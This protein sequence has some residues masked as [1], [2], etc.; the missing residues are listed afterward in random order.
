MIDEVWVIGRSSDCH[1]VVEHPSVSGKH[2]EIRRTSHGWLLKDLGSTNGTYVN[3]VR[4]VPHQAVSVRTTDRILLAN[5][6][7]MPWPNLSA[8]PARLPGDPSS[9]SGHGRNLEPVQP[10]SPG[11]GVPR[12]GSATPAA[13]PPVVKPVSPSTPAAS[14]AAGSNLGIGPGVTGPPGQLAGSSTGRAIRIGRAPDND[15]VLDHPTV[16]RYHARLIETANGWLLEDLGSS[17]GTA[18]GHPYNRVLQAQ[19]GPQDV[20]YLGTLRVPVTDLLNR[21]ERLGLLRP[22]ALVTLGRSGEQL[23]ADPW[24]G[25]RAAQLVQQG[26]QFVLNAGGPAQGLFVNGQAVHG[27]VALRP[28]DQVQFGT[29]CIRIRPDGQLEQ[30]NYRERL[31]VEARDVGVRVKEK[32]LIRRISLTL[33]PRELVALMGPS[34]AGKTTFMMCLCGYSPPSEGDVL[35]NGESLYE[36]YARFSPFLGYVP[37]DDIMHRELTVREA[38]YYSARLRLPTDYS[39]AE[40]HQ[41]IEAVIVQLGL[42]GCEDVLV[43][44]PERKGISGGQRKRV[45]LAMELLTD[46]LVLFLDEP[47]SGLSSEDA[48]LVVQALRKLAD[49]GKIIV[50]TI[51]QPGL[52]AFRLFDHLILVAKDRNSPEPGELVYFGPAYPDAVHFFNPIGLPHL[53]P[54]ADPLPDEILRGLSN[55][56]AQQ[57]V[58][59]YRQSKYYRDFVESRRLEA[60][61]YSGGVHRGRRT[62]AGRAYRPPGWVQAWT[63]VRRCFRVKLRDTWGTAIL[64]AQAPVVALLIVMVFGAQASSDKPDEYFQA[65]PLTIFLTGLAALW[66]GCSN[67]AREIVGEWAIFRREWMVGLR[68]W[69]YLLSKFAI[70]GGLCVLQCFVLLVVIA[71]MCNWKASFASMYGFTLTAAMSGLAIGLCISALARTSEMAVGLLPLVLIPMVV[72][73][74][75]MLPIHKMPAFMRAI[76]WMMPSRWAYE[77]MVVREADAMKDADEEESASK[78]PY[79]PLSHPQDIAERHFPKDKRHTPSQS[80]VWLSA[81]LALQVAAAFAV[82]AYRARK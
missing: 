42:Q 55:R 77:G 32:W 69:P 2:C 47:T 16:S 12:L 48:L 78:S 67:S 50:V 76:S 33:Y 58:M 44:S 10:V 60:D 1:L 26:N 72:L 23:P 64:L 62:S 18:V 28:G 65:K 31:I 34:G 51:H 17:N 37:Q 74:G 61:G 6:V 27:R 52:D 3:G 56:P 4:L 20:V 15:I 70:L 80:F 39:D 40:I 73:G 9:A 30:W 59:V 38:L 13:A 79:G 43:G 66:F 11:G 68:L 14:P 8:P 7:P 53:K 45:N 25:R 75:A 29:H 49:T 41:R 81:L 82:L 36:N 63:L 57:W 46:P 19:V 54:G 21:R 5:L 22:G 24:V 71:P 35:F